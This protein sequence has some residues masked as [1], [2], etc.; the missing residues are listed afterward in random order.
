MLFN[1]LL[2][3]NHCMNVPPISFEWNSK[4]PL[5]GLR[6]LFAWK[7]YPWDSRRQWVYCMWW[8]SARECKRNWSLISYRTWSKLVEEKWRDFMRCEWQEK[9]QGKWNV[10]QV[11]CTCIF[12][13]FCFF[14]GSLNN[15][16][17]II[18]SVDPWS[19]PPKFRTSKRTGKGKK[20]IVY[21]LYIIYNE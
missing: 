16:V 7:S 17:Q 14:F 10:K 1:D 12:F 18:V 5:L 19:P 11:F 20:K 3:T 2:I 21:V 8:T 13:V 4:T 6:L 9:Q 15:S